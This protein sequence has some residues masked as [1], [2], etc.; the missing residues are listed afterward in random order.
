MGIYKISAST[1]Q[2]PSDSNK[3]ISVW[4]MNSKILK[5]TIVKTNQLNYRLFRKSRTIRIIINFKQYNLITH[6]NYNICSIW[7]WII[8]N[9]IENG[10]SCLAECWSPNQTLQNHIQLWC[11]FAE[12]FCPW[13]WL[14]NLV[15]LRNP[16]Q[17]YTLDLNPG[18]MESIPLVLYD[19]FTGGSFH[20]AQSRTC[21]P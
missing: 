13:S 3:Y 5:T 16:T 19:R 21:M 4:M 10:F 2:T 18:Y 8:Q 15:I 14:C 9:I 11:A 6:F 12:E 17:H 7:F 20:Q 1:L